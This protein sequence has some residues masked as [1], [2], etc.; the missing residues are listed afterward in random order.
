[1]RLG[2][3][4]TTL[5]L[6]TSGPVFAQNLNPL[7][8]ALNKLPEVLLTNPA[9]EQAFFVD[10]ASLRALADRKGVE[11]GTDVLRRTQVGA[12]LRPIGA[13]YAG[14]VETWNEKSGI[15]LNEV[16]Y[17]A[18]FGQT[19]YV[20]TLWGLQDTAAATGLID[21]LT[22]R[23]FTPVG[24]DGVVGNGEPM[25][26]DLTKNDPSDPWRGSAGAATF[27]VARLNTVI[28]ASTPD[29]H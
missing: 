18:G 12:M 29:A 7:Y 11:F 25:S 13:L 24:A 3:I 26:V 14:D 17:F 16:R 2:A 1:M 23:D 20:V 8:E 4:A 15:D 6:T 28:Q 21:T 5:L 22:D 10:M 9:P 27:A 19:P